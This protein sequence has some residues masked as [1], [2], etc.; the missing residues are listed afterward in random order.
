MTIQLPQ[1]LEIYIRDQV[2]NGLFAS[3]DEAIADA[4]RVLRQQ[5]PAAPA[6]KLLTPEDVD[7]ELL[8]RGLLSRLP[9]PAEDV[10]DEDDLPIPV[11]GEPVRARIP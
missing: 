7:R 4:I 10:D 11:E 1:D 6:A 3:P 9:D 2:T 5:Q 8:A